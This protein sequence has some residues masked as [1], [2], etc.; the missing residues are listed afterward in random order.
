MYVCIDIKEVKRIL[1]LTE[2]NDIN[3]IGPFFQEIHSSHILARN[4]PL[5]FVISN[6]FRREKKEEEIW[7]N[8]PLLERAKIFYICDFLTSSLAR[9]QQQIWTA[10]ISPNILMK[11]RN[12]ASIFYFLKL[13][14]SLLLMPNVCGT[15]VS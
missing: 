11:V 6:S 14:L 12:V 3:K 2:P 4:N 8:S 7:Q 9:Q 1:K 10:R 15:G 13:F 5:E